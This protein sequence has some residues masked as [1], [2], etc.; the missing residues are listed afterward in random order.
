MAAAILFTVVIG[1]LLG[2]LN[3]SVLISRLLEKEA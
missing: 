3:G 2:N 1:Y